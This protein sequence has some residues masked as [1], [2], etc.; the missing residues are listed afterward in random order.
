[1]KQYFFDVGDSHYIDAERALMISLNRLDFRVG[2]FF[3]RGYRSDFNHIIVETDSEEKMKQIV[4][5]WELFDTRTTHL[6]SLCKQEP[7][8]WREM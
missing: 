3:I 7:L 8:V 6:L 5:F 2:E 1:M 4:L